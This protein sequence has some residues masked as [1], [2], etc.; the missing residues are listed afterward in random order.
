M[1]TPR[2]I[3]ATKNIPTSASYTYF[4]K[5]LQELIAVLDRG[6]IRL[7]DLFH[8]PEATIKLIQH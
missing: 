6:Q 4:L 3:L 8:C 1:P 2:F 7:K 5:E